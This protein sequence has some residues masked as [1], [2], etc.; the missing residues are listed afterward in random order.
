MSN[1]STPHLSVRAL[2]NLI[3]VALALGVAG[4]GATMFTYSQRVLDRFGPQVQSDLEWRAQRG[5]QE[6]ARACDVGLVVGDRAMLLK[7]FG[8]YVNSSDVQAIIA[9][10]AAGAPLAQHG[11]L[12]EAMIGCSGA[13]SRSCAPSQATW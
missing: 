2:R 8:A 6:L 3:F 12:P 1:P 5:A 4:Y 10:N 13:R 7:A 11:H 9:V